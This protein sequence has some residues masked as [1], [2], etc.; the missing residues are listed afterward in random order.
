MNRLT[1]FSPGG[2]LP[3]PFP[4]MSRISPG[5]SINASSPLFR[6]YRALGEKY[7]T[8]TLVKP[9]K[10]SPTVLDSY[11]GHYKF[12]T[13]FFVPNGNYEIKREND[14]LL[15][16]APGADT[17][18]VPQSETEFFDRPF[19]LMIIFGK[20]AQGKVTHVLWR[21]GGRYYRAEKISDN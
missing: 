20:D 19:W 8:P 6:R 14:Q 10:I 18:L 13:D 15:M 4:L 3:P 2:V 11:V 7:E 9:P 16:R 1:I 17:T 5:V 21:Y 12:G